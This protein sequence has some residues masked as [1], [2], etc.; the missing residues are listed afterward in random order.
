MFGQLSG[1]MQRQRRVLV[2]GL[3]LVAFAVLVLALLLGPGAFG[4]RV[5]QLV[6]WVILGLLCFGGGYLV[7]YVQVRNQF[8]SKLIVSKFCVI[9]FWF[10]VAATVLGLA[11]AVSGITVN[12]AAPFGVVAPAAMSL[13]FL[14]VWINHFASGHLGSNDPG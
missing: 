7:P 5:E 4:T 2:L 14:Q 8:V 10:F 1:I 13:G 11:K 3:I 6:V 9:G 12:E